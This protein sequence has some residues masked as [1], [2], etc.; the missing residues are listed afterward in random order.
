MHSASFSDELADVHPNVL[1]AAIL[2]RASINPF[3]Q[4]I[5]R[6]RSVWAKFDSAAAARTNSYS[7]PV[8]IDRVSF[9]E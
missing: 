3:P 9:L 2:V 6:S 7:H 4:T 1:P 8:I 5:F